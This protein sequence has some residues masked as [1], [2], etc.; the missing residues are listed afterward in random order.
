MNYVSSELLFTTGYCCRY[1]T[2]TLP[3]VQYENIIN[4]HQA[5]L[6]I[7][8]WTSKQPALSRSRARVV[9]SF[10]YETAAPAAFSFNTGAAT[11]KRTNR[12]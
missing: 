7:T 12:T 5:S 6:I 10:T 2:H 1:S 11:D 4:V 9:P 8:S 3:R